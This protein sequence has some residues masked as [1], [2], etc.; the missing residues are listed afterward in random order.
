MAY[1][2]ALTGGIGSG[3]TTVANLF[4]EYGVDIVDADIIAREIVEPGMPAWRALKAKFG[5]SLFSA[6]GKLD[7]AALREHIFSHPEDKTWLNTLLHPLIQ[8][9]TQ[10]QLAECLSPWSLWVVP[11]LV[12]NN[13][14]HLA[15][16]V[17]VVDVD[18]DTQLSRTINRD[19]IS[20]YQAEAIFAAQASRES[21][22]AI[23]D[24]I[25]D[26]SGP[27]SAVRARIAQL[28]QHY[29]QLAAAAPQD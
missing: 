25:I 27:P 7:R 3:K 17:L 12:E 10:R 15:D 26:N 20:H 28:N 2:V 1:V 29:H 22:L 4:A 11:L 13:L 18:R 9:E 21:R 24:D 16:R 23:A 8:T 6:D 19:G 5:P 14:Q